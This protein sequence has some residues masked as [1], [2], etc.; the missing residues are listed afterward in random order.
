MR[1]T[2]PM[3][4]LSILLLTLISF[5]VT[6]PST[7]KAQEPLDTEAIDAYIENHMADNQIPGL[8]LSIVHNNEVVYTQ[9]YGVTGPDGTP[10]TPQT[11]FTIG[12]VSK[13]ITALAVMQLVEA[14]K[15]DLDAPIQTYL[16]WF[17]LADPEEAKQITIRHLLTQTSGISPKDGDRGML[18]DDMSDTAL[19]TNI[20]GL[21]DIN[22]NRPVGESFAYANSNFD[23]LGLIV[24]TVSGQSYESYIEDQI[25]TPLEM[26][27]S[28]TSKAEAEAN[29]MAVGHTYYF[30]SPT[31]FDNAPHPRTKLPAGFLISS[32]EDLGHYLIA[33]LNEG[34]YGDVQIL[35]PEYVALMQQPAIEYGNN[36][37]AYGF[38]WRTKLVGGEPSIRHGGDTSNFH[39]DLAF[40]PNRGWGVAVVINYSG[41][42]VFH[43][44]NAPV[45]ELLR[46][47]SGYDTDDAAG[48]LT[49]VLKI[50]WGLII[51]IVTLNIVLWAIF[52]WRR[53][54]NNRPLRLVWH[55]LLP[56][57]L[58]M[59]LLW[60]V[61]VFVP[62][63]LDATL[64]FML[65]F[66]PDLGQ[67]LLVCGVAT[68]LTALTRVVVY[69]A[70]ARRQG[71]VPAEEYQPNSI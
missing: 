36:G 32:A 18:S 53:W 58:D 10:V 50:I 59:L 22:L 54:H 25:Y 9:G 40:S 35:S 63:I 6:I 44:L 27:N 21:G 67:I 28:Y 8:A 39:S 13:P 4:H 38:A 29:G 60:L 24:Q 1:G 66:V 42:P 3:K 55:C 71:A 48:D 49:G 26:A 14:G 20:R 65:V 37:M 56:L 34:R 31:V 33:Q 41:A 7:V 47:T 70:F 19:E 69:I 2:N 12:S 51:L 5:A 11:P 62:G 17:T 43:I 30:G 45:N 61:V 68:G 46:M 64:S 57:A 23:I 16:P 15:I 52:Y